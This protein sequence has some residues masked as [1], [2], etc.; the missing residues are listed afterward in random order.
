MRCIFGYTAGRPRRSASVDLPRQ[1]PGTVPVTSI[2]VILMGPGCCRHETRG[3]WL[4][5]ENGTA[6]VGAVPGKECRKIVAPSEMSSLT[7]TDNRGIA[8]TGREPTGPTLVPLLY[9][10]RTL[11]PAPRRRPVSTRRDPFPTYPLLSPSFRYIKPNPPRTFRTYLPHSLAVVSVVPSP[12]G[13]TGSP[14]RATHTTLS[15]S[16]LGAFA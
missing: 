2:G 14:P 15:P 13:F 11:S 8:S 9:A 4:V 12:D 10:P 16:G 3:S 6:W 5:I 7:S 1:L